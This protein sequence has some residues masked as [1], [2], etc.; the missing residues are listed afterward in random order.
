MS[1]GVAESDPL[2]EDIVLRQV[3]GAMSYKVRTGMDFNLHFNREV[4]ATHES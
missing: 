4:S 3:Q 1:Y 2:T